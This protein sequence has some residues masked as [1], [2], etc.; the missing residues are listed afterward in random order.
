MAGDF[1]RALEDALLEIDV[2]ARGVQLI[3]VVG[4]DRDAV[5]ES[6]PV[7]VHVD[8]ARTGGGVEPA[9][10]VESQVGLDVLQRGALD[11]GAVLRRGVGGDQEGVAFSV[12]AAEP[13]LD[14]GEIAADVAELAPNHGHLLLRLPRHQRIGDDG[15]DQRTGGDRQG[16]LH[17]RDEARIAQGVQRCVAGARRPVAL[18]ARGFSN[19]LGHRFA[20]AGTACHV[21]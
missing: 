6:Q 14:H 17:H 2:G 7:L 11:V 4:I 8:E 19:R 9:A 13:G 18:R 3:A 15:G 16:A 21:R 5:R 1:G 20:D 12:S 10:L